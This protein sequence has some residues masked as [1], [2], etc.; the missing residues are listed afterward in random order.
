MENFSDKGQ[1]KFR[2]TSTNIIAYRNWRCFF[3]NL[4]NFFHSI[5]IFIIKNVANKRKKWHSKSNQMQFSELPY[6]YTCHSELRLWHFTLDFI[7]F[8]TEYIF[9]HLS[10]TKNEKSMTEL[11]LEKHFPFILFH[12]LC[13][14][15]EFS[16]SHLQIFSHFALFSTCCTVH[17]WTFVYICYCLDSAY[18]REHTCFPF[19][20]PHL[21]L[22]I[23][24]PYIFSCKFYDYIFL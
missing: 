8:T 13:L 1:E 24:N 17:I 11:E 19:W 9:A 5:K 3:R 10:T 21:I 14:S 20:R 4:L 16:P 15:P 18:K 12:N 2:R 7:L 23:L 6:S 22:H